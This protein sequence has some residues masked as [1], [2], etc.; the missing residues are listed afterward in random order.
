[1]QNFITVTHMANEPIIANLLAAFL[2]FMIA[3]K[4]LRIIRVARLQLIYVEKSKLS[5]IRTV[6]GISLVAATYYIC[7]VLGWT[8]G[9]PIVQRNANFV[10]NIVLG[11]CFLYYMSYIEK[12]EIP[13]KWRKANPFRIKRPDK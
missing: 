9:L 10:G 13:V 12:H 4:A 6:G 7:N 5:A 2:F 3:Y 11:I 8:E 1:M